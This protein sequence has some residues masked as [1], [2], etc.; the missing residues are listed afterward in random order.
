MKWLKGLVL[1][2]VVGLLLGLWFGVNIGRD[3]PIYA[4]PFEEKTVS[5]H[6]KGAV[7]GTRDTVQR[8]LDESN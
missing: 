2:I 7:E 1:G 3:R 4:N 8:A 6:L 5:E